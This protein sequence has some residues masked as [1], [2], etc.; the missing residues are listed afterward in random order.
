MT[1]T[2]LNS[3]L[4]NIYSWLHQ[5]N[6]NREEVNLLLNVLPKI[7][8]KF[9][10]LLSG[11]KV[12]N[13]FLFPTKEKIEESFSSVDLGFRYLPG[14]Y[15]FERIDSAL[16]NV[17]IREQNTPILLADGSRLTRAEAERK[18]AQKEEK[19]AFIPLRQAMEK[20][21][22]D[23]SKSAEELSRRFLG[24]IRSFPVPDSS[25]KIGE[26]IDTLQQFLQNTRDLA[27]ECMGVLA[28]S[29]TNGWEQK[30][31]FA[32]LLDPIDEDGGLSDAAAR[33]LSLRMRDGAEKRQCRPLIRIRSPDAM[34]GH[35]M[36]VI[37]G[38]VRV[39]HA[40]ARRGYRFLQLVNGASTGI[41]ASLFPAH[42]VSA[43][44]DAAIRTLGHAFALG[45]NLPLVRKSV[46]DES[47]HKARKNAQRMM[48]LWFLNLR[49][50]VVFAIS[51][52]Q[53]EQNPEE[54]ED[55][56]LRENVFQAFDAHCDP[57]W[58]FWR[59]KRFP[60]W[61]GSW[62][63][64][65][66]REQRLHSIV[67]R[68]QAATLFFRLRDRFDEVFPLMSGPY[69]QLADAGNALAEGACTVADLYDFSPEEDG[70]ADLISEFLAL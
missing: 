33:A 38:P 42:A 14:L 60:A 29:D 54:D 68:A 43:K 25:S 8:G 52:W 65:D 63:V 11:R 35:V 23:S 48:A 19:K 56:I 36:T 39:L 70:S 3:S 20:A 17:I 57:T 44:L 67:Q 40:D 12:D 5:D 4:L 21:S 47:P 15:A 26:H 49:S 64:L 1:A 10:D 24:L 28:G 59:Q 16:I 53:S 32:R 7:S 30:E 2:L 41:L 45:A 31:E 46:L 69:D 51:D 58:R 55:E 22:R 66:I 13:T 62:D 61:P 37:S 27:L 50:D 18:L 6:L 9:I 34:A